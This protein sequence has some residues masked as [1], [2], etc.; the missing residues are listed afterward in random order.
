M[1]HKRLGHISLQYIHALIHSGAIQGLSVIDNNA[2]IICDSCEYAKTTRK[3][4]G[5]EQKAPLVQNF[6]DEIHSDLW[7]P[8]PLPSLG[9]HYYYITFT[10]DATCWT[11]VYL[12]RSK[13]QTLDAYKSF[14]AWA[15]TQH[16][17]TIK[18]LHFDCG[19]KFTGNEFTKYLKQEGS[20]WQLTTH[21]TPEHNGVAEA[22]NRCLL[23]CTHA[24]LHSADLP[25]NLWGKTI[26]HA[27]WLKNRTSTKALGNKTPFEKLFGDKPSFAHIPEWG[28]KVWVHSTSGSKFDS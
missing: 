21:N 4:I 22:L 27:V 3:P 23:E 17:A 26:H 11:C 19:G 13:D 12:L 14:A 7:E 5:K 20:E 9:N 16:G 28:Q 15:K 25:K 1:L 24:M 6:R 8:S 10:D 2:P 18:C